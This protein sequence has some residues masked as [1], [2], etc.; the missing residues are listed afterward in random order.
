MSPHKLKHLLHAW[1]PGAEAPEEAERAREQAAGDPELA[2]W[3]EEERQ[4]D[5]AFANK[6]RQLAPPPG[7]AE[8]IIAAAAE[9]KVAVFETR[10]SAARA[11]QKWW[12]PAAA[13]I[14]ASLAIVAGI[15]SFPGNSDVSPAQEIAAPMD[16]AGFI[17]LAANQAMT[18]P[19]DSHDD[20]ALV[21]ET[22]QRAKAPVPDSM[23]LPALKLKA[24]GC[25]PMIVHGTTVSLIRMTGEGGQHHLLVVDRE[26]FGHRCSRYSKPVIYDLGDRFAATWLKGDKLFILVTSRKGEA[27]VR[28]IHDI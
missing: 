25:K 3:L 23:P 15:L 1:R 5:T 17:N 27:I 16:M 28:T 6:L 8:R 21:R 20:F 9:D 11:R 12:V 18:S 14:A 26:R 22:L 10:V 4:F 7:L 2:T 13:G 19:V 24:D